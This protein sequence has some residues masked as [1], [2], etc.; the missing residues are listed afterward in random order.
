MIINPK[1]KTSQE[2]FANVQN[3]LHYAVSKKTAPELIDERAKSDEPHMGLTNWN[4]MPNGK[5]MP[6]DILIAKNYLTEEEIAKLNRIVNMYL[7]YAENQAIEQRP[8]AMKDWAEKL[9]KFLE[10]NEYDLLKGRGKIS[11]NDALKVA[12]EE[13]N[14]FR[15]IQDREFNSDFDKFLEEASKIQKA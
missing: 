14:K 7:D 4:N 9:D 12:K 6:K 2:F 8:M 13:Y 1:S 10:F 15:I 5:V 3:K 11:K